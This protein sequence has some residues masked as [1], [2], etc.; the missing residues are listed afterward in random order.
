MCLAYCGI[1]ALCAAVMWVYAI[2]A[3]KKRAARNAARGR[4]WTPEEKKEL[5]DRGDHN[6]WFVYTT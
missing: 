1:T 5:E 2:A 6:D 4:D 3:N